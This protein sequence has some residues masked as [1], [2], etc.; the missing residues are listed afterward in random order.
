MTVEQIISGLRPIIDVEK[1]PTE[2]IKNINYEFKNDIPADK[3][4]AGI[5][6]VKG[7]LIA[8]YAP[9]VAGKN[10]KWVLPKVST[11]K[12][13]VAFQVTKPEIPYL[14]LIQENPARPGYIK[15]LLYLCASYK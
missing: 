6:N 1:K 9:Y 2:I 8:Q 3:I 13:Y 11:L 15:M 14:L 5:E 10:Y 12:G 7:I 4:A